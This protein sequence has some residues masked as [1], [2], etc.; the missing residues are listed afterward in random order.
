MQKSKLAG[1]IFRFVVALSCCCSVLTGVA[2]QKPEEPEAPKETKVWT[3]TGAEKFLRENDYSARHGNKT[4]K[5]NAFKNEYESAQIVITSGMDAEYTVQLADLKS[6][7]GDVLSKDDFSLYHCKYVYLD[8]I[9][10]SGATTSVGYYPDAL[11]PYETAVAYDENTVGEG[12]NQ[13]VW[14]SLKTGKEQVAGTYT[15]SFK[16]TVGT[17]NYDVPVEVT[18][19][20]YMLTDTTHVKTSFGIS[21]D[22][23]SYAELES[24]FELMQAYY[25]FLLEHRISPSDFPMALSSGYTTYETNEEFLNDVVEAVR[26]PKCSVYRIPTV[27]SSTTVRYTDKDGSQKSASIACLDKATYIEFLQDIA[28]RAVEEDIDLFEKG[29]TYITFCD[30]YDAT[31]SLLGEIKVKYNYNKVRE[32][33]LSVCDWIDLELENT[34]ELSDER[35]TALKEEMKESLRTMQHLLTGESL[36][37]VLTH[38]GLEGEVPKVTFV[39]TIDKYSGAGMREEIHNYADEYG[40]DVWAYTAVNPTAPYPTYHMEDQL[41]SARLLNWMMYDYD[42]VG[43]L[44]WSTTLYKYTGV[45]VQV[46]DYYGEP[47]RYPGMNGDGILLYP[48]REYGIKGPVSCIRLNAIRDGNEDYDLFYELEEIYANRGVSES[49]FDNVLQFL[50]GGLYSNARV[51]YTDS[52]VSDMYSA[53]ELLADMLVAADKAGVVI[54]TYDKKLND[55]TVKVSAPEAVSVKVNGKAL[56]GTVADG[57]CSYEVK[58]DLREVNTFALTATADGKE[59]QV[60]LPLGEAI[61]VVDGTTLL[62]KVEPNKSSIEV[63]DEVTTLEETSVLKISVQDA[64]SGKPAIRLDVSEMDINEKYSKAIIKVYN[65]G[66]TVN[67]SLGGKCSRRDGY[68]SAGETTLASGWNEIEIDVSAFNCAQNGELSLLRIYFNSLTEDLLTDKNEIAIG[69]IILE[70]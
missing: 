36:N 42:I 14:V 12:D 64:V 6:A 10:D 19:Y 59:Y 33:N 38:Q 53:R 32:Y 66:D 35:F 57:T 41:I 63:K 21:Y 34:S 8:V 4:L 24:S 3:A 1:K 65:Y 17:Q 58:L 45:D 44:F 5:I 68:F 69:Q 39:P 54:E 31:G 40:T 52:L 60:T 46:Q 47:L 37:G 20:D 28:K 50:V 16:V 70:N 51:S 67:V 49:A 2:C 15:G 55:V 18:V 9:K 43:N 56:S 22:W 27:G 25:D 13:S 26:N 62:G 48:G 30:E 29:Y 7:S 61:D 11:L 23:I